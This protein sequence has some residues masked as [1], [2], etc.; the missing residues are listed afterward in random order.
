MDGGLRVRVTRDGEESRVVESYACAPFHYLPPSK[1]RGEPPLLTIINSSGGVVGA[2]RLDVEVE[3]DSGAT[4]SLRTQSATRIYRSKG[5][6]ARSRCRFILGEGAL[7]D[8]F[9]DEIIPFAGSDYEQSTEVVLG[10]GAAMILAEI[11]CAGRLA[12]GEAFR[13]SRL[14]LDL[15]CRRAGRIPAEPLLRDRAELRPAA[16]NLEGGAVLGNAT[17]WGSLHVLTTE[18]VDRA[19]ADEV[20]G[21]LDSVAEGAG[22]ATIG[23]AG[24][25]G[26]VAGTSLGSIR[27]VLG[28]AWVVSIERMNRT[29]ET[30]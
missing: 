15:S 18:P 29:R 1:R 7:L 5:E 28:R 30:T 8:Y 17:I 14:L 24:V 11:V 26:R 27:E 12:R 16:G 20:D 23:P 9:P 6:P 25:F 22:G 4:L 3:L 13:F 21:L 19:F 10:P 2:D